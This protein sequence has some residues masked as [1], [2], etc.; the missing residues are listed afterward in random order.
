MTGPAARPRAARTRAGMPPAPGCAGE[1]GAALLMAVLVAAALSILGGAV[2]WFAVISAHTSAAARDHADVEAALHAA[3]EIAAA[4]LAVEPDLA[5][6]RRGEAVAAGNGASALATRDGAVDVASLG[7]ALD[8][9]R[10]RL[11]P[12]ADVAVWRPYL[13][14]RLGEHLST[15][16]GTS[17]LDPLIAAWVRGDDAAGLGPAVVEIAIEAV[18][19]SGARAGAVAVVRVGPRGA[20]IDAVWPETGPAGPG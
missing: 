20:A 14:G 8:R 15:P 13:W 19:P 17:R 5:V 9:R 7:L 10:R 3:L 2:T 4:S 6:V 11:R 12:P 1:R 18:G 16:I